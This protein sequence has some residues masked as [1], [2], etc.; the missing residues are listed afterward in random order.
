M[1]SINQRIFYTLEK[2]IS[3]TFSLNIVNYTFLHKR[4]I[5]FCILHFSTKS[6][7]VSYA[8]LYKKKKKKLHL[9]AGK[10]LS[11]SFLLNNWRKFSSLYKVAYKVES[12]HVQSPFTF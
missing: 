10:T 12:E 2:K 11:L 6:S 8:C 5:L 4:Y 3:S 9:V 7:G 1:N